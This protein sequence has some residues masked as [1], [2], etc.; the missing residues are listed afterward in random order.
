MQLTEAQVLSLAPDDASQ[1]AGRGLSGPKK[2]VTL[3]ANEQALWGEC[4]GSG[5]KPYQTRVDFSDL[6]TKCS[7]PSRKFPCKHAIGL[8]LMYATSP[9]LLKDTTAPGWVTEWIDGR[10]EKQAAKKEKEEKPVN[11]EQQ[12]KRQ[13]ARENKVDGGI[14]ELK[15]WLSDLLHTGL[16]QVNPQTLR[17]REN[18]ERRLIDAQAPG[19][20]RMVRN[21][22][23]SAHG[24]DFPG[25]VMRQLGD[26]FLLM[27]AY[28]RLDTLP[29]LLRQDVRTAIGFTQDQKALLEQEGLKDD[30]LVI[31]QRIESDERLWSRQTYFYALGSQKYALVLD[32]AHGQPSFNAVYA[33]GSVLY[34]EMVH[35]ASSFP[36]RALVK[37]SSVMMT[38]AEPIAHQN[39]NEMLD[40]YAA[41]VALNPWM[42]TFPALI[43][44][45]TISKPE[46][47]PLF[48]DQEGQLLITS[49]Y[50]HDFWTLL[51]VSGGHPISL[52]GVYNG[53]SF[54]PLSALAEGTVIPLKGG[55]P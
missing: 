8:M 26:L 7:C 18:M 52:F 11:Q 46:S 14:Q 48:R 42:I 3:G 31:G 5:S 19:L 24:Q 45:I 9:A 28:E 39:I 22:N 35:F 37:Q 41:A 49:T 51:S 10:K 30:W 53:E 25:S 20:A 29:E 16:A 17:D 15:I 54:M 55:N 43:S 6:T 23:F 1:K 12:A 32:Y 34:A 40:G 33:V 4:Q 2:W 27:Q 44:N 21:L 47:G 50:D 36:L 38:D 13:Q